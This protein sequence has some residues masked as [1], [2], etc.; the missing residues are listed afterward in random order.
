MTLHESPPAAEGGT[1]GDALLPP[2]S[3]S[4]LRPWKAPKKE[5]SFAGAGFLA[6]VVCC[7][8]KKGW[9]MLDLNID[10]E[11]KNNLC[12]YLDFTVDLPLGGSGGSWSKLFWQLFQ[13]FS[14]PVLLAAVSFWQRATEQHEARHMGKQLIHVR[15][16]VIL[17]KP[18]LSGQDFQLD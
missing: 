1:A 15:N 16:S 9:R 17:L 2:T 12:F 5:S 10:K 11:K 7:S 14:W 13:H 4:R 3:P 6:G 8:W 18:S